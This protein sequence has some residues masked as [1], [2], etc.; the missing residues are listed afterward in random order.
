MLI[1]ILINSKKLIGLF[2]LYTKHHSKIIFI[3]NFNL[4]QIRKCL[5]HKLPLHI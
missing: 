2:Q 1:H 3:D 5:D 4:E